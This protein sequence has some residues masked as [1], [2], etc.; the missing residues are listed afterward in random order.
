M[1]RKPKL[2]MDKI[3]KALGAERRGSVRAGGGHFGAM[4]LVAEVQARF[5]T[6]VGGGRGTD[7]SW[8]EKRLLPLAPETL[9]RLEHLAEEITKKGTTI[10]PLQVAALLLEHAID[11]VDDDDAAELARRAAG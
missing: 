5:K 7:P 10:S 6:P 1:K 11:E 8:T 9:H 3:A 2:N 4:Q